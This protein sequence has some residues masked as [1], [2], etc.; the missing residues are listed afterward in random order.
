[1]AVRG[2]LVPQ[3][4]A[5]EPA[6]K[7]LPG[8]ERER[9]RRLKA[10]EIKNSKGPAKLCSEPFEIPSGWIWL[11]LWQ[12]G[13][14]FTGN[15]INA[16]LRS[17][18]AAN[19]EGLPFVATKD[20]GYGFEPIDYHNG[21]FVSF[22]DERFNIAQP[23]SVFICAEGGSAG[24]K[25][26]ISDRAIA[27]GNKLIANEPWPQIDPRYVL[28]TYLSDFFFG[29]FSREMTGIIGGI[30]RAKFLALPFPLP[31]LAEQRRIVAKVD[32]LIALCD[33]L[34]RESA[35]AL[36]A[37]QTL[38]DTLLTTLVNSADAA[39][40]AAN[41]AR[42]ESHFDT[43]FT[44]EASIAALQQAILDLAVRG[45]LVEQDAGD[46]PG[47]TLLKRIKAWQ[48]EQVAKKQIRLPRKPLSPVATDEVPADLPDNWSPVRLGEIIYI[49]SGDGLTSAQMEP[50]DI[51][52][53]GGN[54][55]NGYHDQQNVFRETIVI[56]RVGFYCGSIHVTPPAAWVTD[57][58][59]VT[60]FD[61]RS[62]HLPFLRLLLTAT[63]LKEDENATAQPVISGA[64]VYPI[65]VG[66]PP[67][68]EQH[69]IVA[70]VD[71]LM[72]L[73]N[74]LRARLADAAE[75]RR[76]LADAI[77]ERATA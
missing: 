22:D 42:L 17:E 6:N 2:K 14:I 49:Q 52:V 41:W 36:A 24:R 1:M 53:F 39:D 56:G 33:A 51:P 66:L 28:C 69:R 63:N 38:V 35:D 70:K 13:N 32:E 44:T 16:T 65:V 37:H 73:C 54:G 55:I 7:L 25:M 12:T 50:G 47:T 59:F 60:H 23:N 48:A 10:K 20:V 8:I 45:K 68:A 21:L 76:H 30:S 34:E 46:E 19:G 4:A 77:V 43:L 67:L 72:A 15:S 62:I 31:P 61:E 58:A 74:T 40:L 18:L 26:A 75:N 27:F 3:D 57:N 9:Q 5:E 11:P 29:C 64:K 71:E